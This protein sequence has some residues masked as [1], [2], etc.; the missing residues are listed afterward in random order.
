[1]KNFN[2]YSIRTK[3]IVIFIVFKIIPL[4]L[5][6]YIGISSFFSINDFLTQTSKNIITSSQD[7]IKNTTNAAIS[8]SIKALDK[9]SQLALEQRTLSIAQ[10]IADFLR[11]RDMDILTLA[12]HP[13]SQ[14]RLE[15]FYDLKKSTVH[16]PSQYIYDAKN[17]SWSA[18][19]S[20][21]KSQINE[22]A[23][24]KDNEVNFHKHKPPQST[25]KSMPLYKE[26]T[27]Y[28]INGMEIYKASTLDSTLKNIAIKEN[29]FIKAEDYFAPANSL[30]KGEIYVSKVI[31]EYIPSPIIGLFSKDNAQKAN[32]AFEPEKYA[33][34]GAEN[35]LGKKFSGIIR[36]VTPIYDGDKK[37][38][39]LTMALDHEHIMN[40][41]DFIDPLETEPMAI[42][43]AITG[44]YA[45][46]WGADFKNISHPRDY[47]INGYDSATG[48]PVPGWIDQ[49][50][51]KEFAQSNNSD[52]NTFLATKPPFLDQ[53]L[54]KKPNTAQIKQGQLG[55]DCKYLNFSP[56]CQGWAQLTEDGG[57]G[58]F[59]IFFSDIWKLTTAAAIPYYTGQYALTPR[60]FGFV[61]MGANVAQFHEAATKTKND[62]EKIF[63]KENQNIK[64]SIM[65]ITQEIKDNITNQIQKMGAVTILLVVLIIYIAILIS[66]NISK[67]ITDLIIGTQK[68]KNANFDYAIDATSNDEIG[69]LC[70]SFNEMAYSIYNLNKD[71]ND[72]LFTDDLTGL[73]N[74]RAFQKQLQTLKNPVVI[75]LDIDAFKNIN[76]F[77]GTDAGNFILIAFASELQLFAQEKNLQAY[78]ISSDEF[79]L[80]KDAQKNNHKSILLLQEFIQR[81][82]NKIFKNEK[83][84]IETK[85][86]FTCGIASGVGNLLEKADLALNEAKKSN[87]AYLAYDE[88]NNNM[89]TF[90]DH[91]MWRKKIE[92][93]I[94]N[95]MIV[96]YFQEI[97][98]T[99]NPHNKKYEALIRML[100]P[101]GEVISPYLFLAIAKGTKLYPKLT[102][103]MIQKTFEKFSHVD[104]EFSLNLSAEDISNKKTLECIYEHIGKYDLGRKVIFELLESE[105]ILNFDSVVPFIKNMKTLGVRFAIDDFGSGYSNFSY[106]LKLQPDFIKID[107]SLIKNISQ[108]SNEFH[109]VKAIVSFAKTLNILVVAEHVSS[110]EIVDILQSF[111]IE[112]LQGFYFS[113]PSA[114]V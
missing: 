69:V 43:S 59:V 22:K 78:R 101:D 7:S 74:R 8:D 93:A 42:S 83:L 2:N 99:K 89:N 23:K 31:G 88:K 19:S 84:Q 67:R 39:Y 28:D 32:I 75:L 94:E 73:D 77:Y 37:T 49:Q 102:Q 14:K 6:S 82:E 68:L 64:N 41:T 38:G 100:G 104:A 56:Q 25:Q 51:A 103:I 92:V 96:P 91:V 35:P 15:S 12:Q 71:L 50:L 27:Y 3:L 21:S 105:E 62:I 52:L 4:F 111:D 47:F 114:L 44:N 107:G 112:F 48:E 113:E 26:I 66:N 61:T 106:L 53:S 80:L 108:N 30:Q 95:D 65:G 87:T 13:M 57:Y 60:G 20:V 72:K 16:V 40:F 76:D 17:D 46:I 58:S 98:D 18:Q 79:I 29:T 24:L 34:A 109:I 9:K 81:I 97:I 33:Y 63:E 11:Q 55:L 1:M 54:N 90:R 110:K 5:L 10:A 70:T 36:F 86:N 85:I 45:F